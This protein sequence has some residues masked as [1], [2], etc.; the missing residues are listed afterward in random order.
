[1]STAISRVFDFVTS[2]GG[3]AK[4]II[5]LVLGL[6]Y[7]KDFMQ[8]R[9]AIVEHWPEV[10]A[11]LPLAALV[12]AACGLTLIGADAW[13]WFG[14]RRP[15]E[16]FRR[17]LPKIERH[18]RYHQ[19]KGPQDNPSFVEDK[20]LTAAVLAQVGVGLPHDKVDVLLLRDLADQGKLRE[21]R[22]KYPLTKAKKAEIESIEQ[23][24]R[25]H[26]TP[27]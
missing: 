22:K 17:L 16:R 9:T 6:G 8:V 24:L 25:G 27:R 4:G 5:F 15:S 19:V 13:R 20:L 1:M 12:A 2:L 26:A 18:A 7:L 3:C 10:G 11:L 23:E 21:A 14:P